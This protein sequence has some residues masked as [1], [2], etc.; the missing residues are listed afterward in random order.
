M[1]ILDPAGFGPVRTGLPVTDG[2]M[3]EAPF[4]KL[5]GIS[6]SFSTIRVL[7]DISLTLNRG[8]VLA[9]LG[10]NGAGKST[11]KN[12][13]SGLMA[14]S[15]GTIT[16]KGRAYEALSLRDI[17]DLGFGTIHQELSLF[18]N[19]T[20]AENIYMPDLLRKHGLVDWT[21]LAEGAARLLHDELGT[22]IDPKAPLSSLSLG[23]RQMVEAAKA[24]RRARN[25]LIFD[26]PTTCLSLP[27]RERL[28]A[29]VRKLKAAGYAII[30]ITHFLEEVYALADSVV[31]MRDGVIADAGRPADMDRDRI[32]RAMV[33][34]AIVEGETAPTPIEQ[35]APTVLKLQDLSDT[36]LVRGVSL[37]LRRGEIVGIAGLMGAGRSEL[38]EVICG[39][40]DG[41]G[42]V[43]L[44][45]TPFER[46]SPQAAIA[47]G[48]V[49][50]SEDRRL[51]QAFLS[52]P[53]RENMS[54]PML[55][56]LA[57]RLLGWL[58]LSREQRIVGQLIQD[59]G[60]QPARSD[61]SMINLS[62]GNQQKAII[63][64]WLTRN[65]KVAILDEPTKGVDIGARQAVHRLVT[66]FAA[67]GMGF[68]LISSDIPELLSLSHR[69]AVLHKG[70]L[71]GIVERADF[72]AGRIL[73]MAST[74]ERA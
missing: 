60:V 22:K 37:D 18:D 40:R 67:K 13:L 71:A 38:A 17:G 35:G 20:V 50:V 19:L 26:E 21:A 2:G 44:D 30:Y 34:R 68:I 9:L 58:D 48:L 52:R 62:G 59:Y 32:A 65:P 41:T 49:L 61:I 12:I 36:E 45:G 64:R 4:L 73:S 23:E 31:I 28:F 14:P 24:I 1:T 55:G 66:D 47:R 25:L 46:R 70:Q 15:G 72:D 3:S 5:S 74:G 56:D 7:R 57:A 11:L 39:L 42:C 43:E 51:D 69:I 8:E 33:G 63:G 27:E 53:V 10:E 29:V 16:V 54:A 6:K